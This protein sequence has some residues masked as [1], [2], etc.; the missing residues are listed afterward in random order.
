[1][2][3]FM[4][5]KRISVARTDPG[6][7]IIQAELDDSIYSL[8]LFLQVQ[9][10]DLK[11]VKIR[12]NW[13][14]WTTP[15]C[16]RALDFL[17]QAEGLFLVPGVEDNIHKTIGRTACRHF[18]NL[19]IECAYAAQQA[20]IAAGIDSGREAGRVRTGGESAQVQAGAENKKPPT[21][22]SSGTTVE[23][24][25]DI[26]PEGAFRQKQTNKPSDQGF[27]VDLHT[28]TFPASACASDSAEQ[29]VLSARKKGLNAI[30]ITDHNHVWEK[31]DIDQLIDRCNFQ[32]FRGN[33]ILTDQGDMLVFGFFDPVDRVIKLKDLKDLVKR[34]GG[35]IVAAHPFRGFLTFGTGQLGLTPEK[36]ME[37]EMFNH[38]NAVEI[39]NGKVTLREN[40]LAK[41]VA[42]GLKLPMTGGSDAH[43]HLNVGIYATC[44]KQA[45]SDEKDFL[46]ALHSGDFTPVNLQEVLN[47]K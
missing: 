30:C 23:K 18:A 35:F 43:D 33:E 27:M 39:L 47:E 1:M 38:V 6:I 37:R 16:P 3:E 12:G 24:E 40:E 46:A 5:N 42:E 36:A 8:E 31:K 45:F 20:Q 28:H 14:R 10:A 19:L 4:R 11:C 22:S 32:V 41:R 7:F 2:L 15:E 13:R 34:A 44:F 25:P 17:K 26:P 29:M 21:L 9:T